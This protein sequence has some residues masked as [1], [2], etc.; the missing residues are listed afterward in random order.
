M[1]RCLYNASTEY[2]LSLHRSEA[3]SPSVHISYI[4]LDH[5][6]WERGRG[7]VGSDVDG[8]VPELSCDMPEQLLI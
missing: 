4:R 2:L 8:I 7:G 5:H 1:V 3:S 6:H